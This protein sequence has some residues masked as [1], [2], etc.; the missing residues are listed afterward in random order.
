M[1]IAS[2]VHPGAL[3]A[4]K[5]DDGVTYP[6][7]VQSVVGEHISAAYAYFG[8]AESYSLLA[9]DPTIMECEVMEAGSVKEW[10]KLATAIMNKWSRRNDST[11]VMMPECWLQFCANWEARDAA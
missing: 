3:I 1:T 6:L 5:W 11:K 10:S 2:K 9:T 4:V 8:E 7:V